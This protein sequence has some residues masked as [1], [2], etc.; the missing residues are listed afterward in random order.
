MKSEFTENEINISE[1]KENNLASRSSKKRARRARKGGYGYDNWLSFLKIFAAV[2]VIVGTAAGFVYLDKYVR[3]TVARSDKA[4]NVQVVNPPVWITAELKKKLFN[5]VKSNGRDLRLD[6][7]TAV[8]VQQNI[9]KDFCWADNVR[10]QTTGDGIRIAANWRK[11]VAMVRAGD[12]KYYV[13]RDMVVLDYVMMSSLPIVLVEGLSAPAQ[14]PGPGQVWQ[15]DDVAAA[16]EILLKLD[17]MD[18]RSTPDKPLLYEIDKVD[19]SNYN[20]RKNS[21]QPHII[22]YTKDKCEI[23]WGAPLGSWQRYLEASDEE[24]LAKLYSL[25]KERGTLLNG[26]KYINLCNPQSSIPQ[27]IDKYQRRD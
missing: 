27:P 24:K 2:I 21:K 4:V 6:D 5:V 12:K 10:V 15:R 14:I 23:V 22:L 9:E 11:P 18:Q 16:V 25:F 8:L 7:K 26:I 3:K 19:V 17:Q 1:D 20:G 13:D